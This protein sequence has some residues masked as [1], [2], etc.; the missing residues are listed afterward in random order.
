MLAEIPSSASVG[1]W[2]S[3]KWWSVLEGHGDFL[4]DCRGETV[5]PS[6][7]RLLDGLG[8]GDRFGML[9]QSKLGRGRLTA[10]SGRSARV[11]G[12][13]RSMAAMLCLGTPGARGNSSPVTPSSYGLL[14]RATSRSHCFESKVAPS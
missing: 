9:R 10:M 11:D 7:L 1:G 13:P 2:Q 5:H 3:P 4:P 6:T 12:L 14:V 8:L